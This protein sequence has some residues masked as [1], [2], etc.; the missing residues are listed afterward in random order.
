MGRGRYIVFEGSEGC[1]KSTHAARL[2]ADL[3]AVLTRETGG[4]R[5]GGLVRDI[6]HDTANTEL[7]ARAEALLIA[8]DRAQHVA[9]VIAPAIA[10]GRHVVSDRSVYSSLAYQSYGRGL[11][12]AKVRDFNT[13]A[14]D[15]YWPEL[16]LFLD[17]PTEQLAQRMRRRQLDRFEAEDEAF[18]QRVIEGFHEMA[19]VEPERWVTIDA[20]QPSAI[21]AAAIRAAVTERLGL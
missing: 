5:I 7:T 14:L 10:S 17:V 19:A 16:V 13:W 18:H 4:T 21:T 9:E 3:D 6:L 15:G 8:G 2:A 20:S 1:G 12:Y 11:T